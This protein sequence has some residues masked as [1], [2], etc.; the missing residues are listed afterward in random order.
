V[1]FLP[2]VA[3]LYEKRWFALLRIPLLETNVST[4]KDYKQAKEYTL[5]NISVKLM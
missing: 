5:E 2:Y 1:G 4:Y 3:Q